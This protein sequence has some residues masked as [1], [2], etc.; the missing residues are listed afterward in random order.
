MKKVVLYTMKGCPHCADMKDMLKEAKIKFTERDIHKYE[1]EY[2]LFV[3]AT[4]NEYIPAFM[5]M[6]LTEDKKP[7]DVKLM[8]PDNDFDD[9]HEA[10]HHVKSYLD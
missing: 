4:G 3:E 2:D 10:L 7:L 6:T 8:A 5:L 1:K 9:L